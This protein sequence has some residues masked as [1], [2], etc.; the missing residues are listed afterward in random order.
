MQIG[1]KGIKDECCN[2]E[3]YIIQ[4]I[5]A[6]QEKV[7]NCI[8]KINGI[9]PDGNN[10]FNICAGRN[11]DIDQEGNG[12]RIHTDTQQMEQDISDLQEQVQNIDASN[13]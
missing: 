10:N 7:R 5:T 3:S 1:R 2:K 9:A 6:M 11:I 4:L 8:N 12:I 13:F